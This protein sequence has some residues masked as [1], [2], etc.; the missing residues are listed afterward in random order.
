MLSIIKPQIVFQLV[1]VTK[2][3]EYFYTWKH[4]NLKII[5]YS[6]QEGALPYKI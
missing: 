4:E 6:S 5:D 1:R 3:S 2:Y